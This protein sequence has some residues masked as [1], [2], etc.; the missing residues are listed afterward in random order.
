MIQ[1]VIVI[2]ARAVT[3]RAVWKV[4]Q[5]RRVQSGRV[6]RPGAEHRTRRPRAS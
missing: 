4:R 3:P 6:K 1:A 5:V 2:A